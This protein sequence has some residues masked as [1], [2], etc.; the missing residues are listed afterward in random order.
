MP[1]RIFSGGAY[2][3]DFGPGVSPVYRRMGQH[4]R[5]RGLLRMADPRGRAGRPLA[6]GDY[7]S[8]SAGWSEAQAPASIAMP[9]GLERLAPKD[10]GGVLVQVPAGIARS[11]APAAG[12]LVRAAWQ[13][14]VTVVVADM[15]SVA[16]WDDACLE[17]LLTA[18]RNLVSRRA[19]LRLVVWSAD[20]YTALQTTGM[21]REFSIYASIDA[22]MRNL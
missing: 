20:L 13:P 1:L 11:G 6:D 9:L 2:P 3:G 8:A 14:G 12:D 4:R 18:H 15:A 22:A 10:R 16:S 19:R 5:V 21:G 17:S 7:A